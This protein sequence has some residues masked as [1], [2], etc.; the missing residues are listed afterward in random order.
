MSVLSTSRLLYAIVAVILIAATT[1]PN[2]KAFAQTIPGAGAPSV[3]PAGGGAALLDASDTA[4]LLLDHQT[5]L[6]QTVKDISVAEL[7]SNTT[8]IAKTGDATKNSRHYDCFRAK[9]SERSADAGNPSVRVARAVRP[10]QG[11]GERLG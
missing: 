10:S 4:I 1:S 2:L 9:R 6:F 3:L 5:G 7:R 8:M 11:R